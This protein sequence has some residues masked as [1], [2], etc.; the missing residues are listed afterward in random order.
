MS[1]F[2]II[3]ILLIIIGLL[4]FGIAGYCYWTI[5][6]LHETFSYYGLKEKDYLANPN[7][8]VTFAKLKLGIVKFSIVG[9]IAWFLS[10]IFFLK[11]KNK[12]SLNK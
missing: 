9:A 12:V 8:A 3:S 6:D 2:L 4:L 1:K 7:T 5:Q 11:R 10:L